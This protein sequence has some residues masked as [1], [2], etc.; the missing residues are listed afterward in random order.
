[1]EELVRIA[2]KAIEEW[3][4]N[5]KKIEV[6]G[7]KKSGVFVTITRYSNGELRGCI[8]FPFPLKP[9]REATVEAAIEATMDPRFPPLKESE[10]DDIIVEVTVLGKMEKLEGDRKDFPK[11]IEIGRDGL[12]VRYKFYSGI[13]LPQVPVEYG[14]DSEEFLSQTC[15]KAGLPSDFWKR[16]DVEVYKFKGEVWKEEKPKGK[17]VREFI[18]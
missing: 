3:V 8:G 1:M 18:K 17:I 9:L 14:W 16:E 4:R 7:G 6:H 11:K 2:R 5:H 15:I 10:L 12:Y 13:L